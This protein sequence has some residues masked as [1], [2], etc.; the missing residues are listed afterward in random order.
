LHH[1][2][3]TFG[4][5]GI[6]VGRVIQIDNVVGPHRAIESLLADGEIVTR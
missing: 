3:C 6:P 2:D 4:S 1:A 5:L